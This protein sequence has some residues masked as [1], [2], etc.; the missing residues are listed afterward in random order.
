MTKKES[1]EYAKEE[2]IRTLKKELSYAKR[3]VG[4]LRRENE[5]LSHRIS[6]LSPS[7]RKDIKRDEE[8]FLTSDDIDSSRGYF[9]YIIRKFKLTFIYKL[10]DRTFFAIRKYLFA[11]RLWKNFLIILAIFGTSFQA[12]I[13]FGSV[14]VIL[15]SALLLSAVFGI[16]SF[17]SYRN[18]RKKLLAES[19]GKKMYFLYARKKKRGNFFH[20]TVNELSARGKVFIVTPYFSS[21]G[22]SMMKKTDENICF[23]HTSFYFGFISHAA[24][25]N[26]KDIV[27]IY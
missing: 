9:G 7:E 15:P 4:R 16:F 24:K 12:I 10:Y 6:L 25:R 20:C 27:K 11:S 2:Q 13:T 8:L 5:Y 19:E 14:L 21:C 23:I 18:A 26:H 22:F 1:S 17:F 3:E